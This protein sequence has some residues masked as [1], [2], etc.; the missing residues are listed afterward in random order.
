MI[1]W[2]AITAVAAYPSTN[3]VHPSYVL[4]GLHLHQQTF[5]SNAAL[6]EII[7]DIPNCSNTKEIGW[8]EK[9]LRCNA[10]RVPAANMSNRKKY[11]SSDQSKSLYSVIEEGQW[12]RAISHKESEGYIES[13]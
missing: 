12:P 7:E 8:R 6:D 3:P 4:P 13:I 10:G 2:K 1:Y 5:C 11:R 9:D